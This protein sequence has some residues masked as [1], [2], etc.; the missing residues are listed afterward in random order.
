LYLSKFYEAIEDIEGVKYV[1]IKRFTRDA[2]LE[3]HIDENGIIAMGVNEIPRI[4]N[5]SDDDQEYARGI[6]IEELTTTGGI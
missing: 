3:N 6:F 2:D 5:D 1:T 4:P